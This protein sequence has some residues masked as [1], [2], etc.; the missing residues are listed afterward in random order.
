MS[1]RQ[2]RDLLEHV[3]DTHEVVLHRAGVDQAPDELA[4]AWRQAAAE[5]G[6]AYR[7]WCEL[8]GAEAHAAYLAAEDRA[9]AAVAALA[10][11]AGRAA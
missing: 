7:A 8:P 9:D 11:R 2:L 10:A 5:A 4:V 6:A 1:P 3:E